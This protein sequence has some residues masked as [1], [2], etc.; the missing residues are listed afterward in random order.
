MLVKQIVLII[1]YHFA[2]TAENVS[3]RFKRY[4]MFLFRSHDLIDVNS[5]YTIEIVD[6][7][8]TTGLT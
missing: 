4:F 1:V 2:I 8:R 3:M 6:A 7:V 5:K